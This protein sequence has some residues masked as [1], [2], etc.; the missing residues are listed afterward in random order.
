M[1][2][3]AS[4]LDHALELLSGVGPI[5]AR[6]MFGGYGVSLNGISIGII[7]DDRLYLRTD[8][9]TRPQ[10][11]SAGASPF[12]SPSR[13]GPMVMNSYWSLP[14]EAVDDPDEAVAWGRLAVE[15]ALRADTAKKKPKAAKAKGTPRGT[16]KTRA[17]A[18]APPAARRAGQKVSSRPPR[19]KSA[20]R[21]SPRSRA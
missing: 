16:P 4:F 20:S 2:T 17:P 9:A 13:K 3:S 7:D 15:A 8:E 1:P 11:Q 12:T 6:A 5:R 10:F 19:K 18:S 14:D 21:S